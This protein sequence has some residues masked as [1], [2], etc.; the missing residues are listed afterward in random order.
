MASRRL[1]FAM[2]LT[3]VG[4]VLLIT[5]LLM[6]IVSE[7]LR[8]G[9][10]NR[11]L[12]IV[13]PGELLVASGLGVGV[14]LLVALTV[15][16]ADRGQGRRRRLGGAGRRRHPAG[17]WLAPVSQ[18]PALRTVPAR[19]VPPARPE[20]VP[21]GRPGSGDY[22]DDGWHP[23]G[24]DSWH[25]VGNDGWNP[26][27]A[28]AWSPP[29]EADWDRAGDDG[30]P[31]GDDEAWS[32]PGPAAWDD[33][34]RRSGPG[35]SPA[36][37]PHHAHLMGQ[38]DDLNGHRRPYL[39]GPQP[40]YAAGPEPGRVSG[41]EAMYLAGPEPGP[42]PGPEPGPVTG[43]GPVYASD[44]DA[45]HRYAAGPEAGDLIRPAAG[46]AV[47]DNTS[48]IPAIRG[49]R[50]PRPEPRE[51]E[52]VPAPKPFSVWEPAPKPERGGDGRSDDA[53]RPAHAEPP[54]ADTQEKIEQIK[55]LYLTA[56]AIG[57][58]AL[59]Q[60]FDQLRQRQRSLI[61]E[62]FEKAGLGSDGTPASLGGD[63]AQN[64][65]SLPG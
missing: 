2:G 10:A 37:G 33:D 38:T 55:D 22:A 5:G 25:P 32:P 4:A 47:D 54:S 34:D 18:V 49:T 1:R 7:V 23:V 12:G 16:R 44:P 19:P 21:A 36:T 51:S 27:P 6:V 43:P 48:P 15:A 30:W 29:G 40:V 11:G 13:R 56:E 65:A 50:Q 42:G 60:H 63:S 62:F 9:S 35:P 45:E 24:N 52:P 59:G 39:S 28:Y 58:D 64:G 41:P 61:R 14:T 53:Y 31:P 20:P 3:I 8:L 17:Q 57:E 26:G 46:L